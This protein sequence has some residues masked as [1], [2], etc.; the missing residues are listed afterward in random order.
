MR[1]TDLLRKLIS[2]CGY[3]HLSGIYSEQ[4]ITDIFQYKLLLRMTQHKAKK[5]IRFDYFAKVRMGG[6]D[7]IAKID[8]EAFPNVNNYKIH[9]KKKNRLDTK[10][11]CRR[12]S[13]TYRRRLCIKTI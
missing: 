12:R 10:V 8:V 5:T 6:T 7:Y 13:N 2:I 3:L 1:N 4:N 11:A 9:R